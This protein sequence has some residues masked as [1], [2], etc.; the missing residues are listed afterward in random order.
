MHSLLAI[1]GMNVF[2]PCET[3]YLVTAY[4]RFTYVPRY[5]LPGATWKRQLFCLAWLGE[6]GSG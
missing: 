2:A 5:V 6:S 1:I 4:I 3:L